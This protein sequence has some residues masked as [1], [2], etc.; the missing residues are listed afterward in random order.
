MR[1]LGIPAF[2]ACDDTGKFDRDAA[3]ALGHDVYLRTFTDGQDERCMAYAI[4][5]AGSHTDDMAR[6]PEGLARAFGVAVNLHDAAGGDLTWVDEEEGMTLYLMGSLKAAG[7]L[8]EGVTGQDVSEGVRREYHDMLDLWDQPDR[9]YIK[10]SAESCTQL[11]L[12][13]GSIGLG[14]G[15]MRKVMLTLV[16]GNPGLEPAAPARTDGVKQ[17]TVMELWQAHAAARG[18]TE[19]PSDFLHALH[20]F[21]IYDQKNQVLLVVQTWPD[22]HGNWDYEVCCDKYV[23]LDWLYGQVLTDELWIDSRGELQDN[24]DWVLPDSPVETERELQEILAQ[25]DWIPVTREAL[26]AAWIESQGREIAQA[27][28]PVGHTITLDE[29]AW[30]MLMEGIAELGTLAEERAKVELEGRTTND[31]EEWIASM[32][33]FTEVNYKVRKLTEEIVTTLMPAIR[34]A[35][36]REG[37]VQERDQ[38]QDLEQEEQERHVGGDPR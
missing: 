1:D 8:E 2:D 20:R 3:L 29:G 16:D 34:D 17:E 35:M 15:D 7:W 19:A 36:D 33:H 24:E 32:D 10:S 27:V 26:G 13:F 18:L 9:D 6:S 30:Q 25:G 21:G 14:A 5:A 28:A 22:E 4:V 37:L 38:N 23:H 11:L 31:I 12:K